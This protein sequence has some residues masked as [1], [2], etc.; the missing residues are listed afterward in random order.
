MTACRIFGLI[1]VL[2]LFSAAQAGFFGFGSPARELL[3]DPEWRQYHD[4]EHM[5]ETLMRVAKKCENISRLYTIGKSVEGRDL[6]VIEFSTTP[7]IHESG[8]SSF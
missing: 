2:A 3:T 7:G 8:M 5:E 6:L 1:A 4:Q